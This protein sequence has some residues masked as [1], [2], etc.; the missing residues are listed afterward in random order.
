MQERL[1]PKSRVQGSSYTPFLQTNELC[2]DH[3]VGLHYVGP[4]NWQL[5]PSFQHANDV[6]TGHF[7]ILRP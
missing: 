6:F 3:G 7:I 5:A 2:E 1:W 4:K